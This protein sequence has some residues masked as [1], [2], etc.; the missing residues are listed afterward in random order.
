MA[1]DLLHVFWWLKSG[2]YATLVF[3]NPIYVQVQ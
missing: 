2:P 1:G 3:V